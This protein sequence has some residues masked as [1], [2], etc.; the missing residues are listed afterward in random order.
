MTKKL[1]RLAAVQAVLAWVV[2]GYI[3]F[4]HRTI[5]WEH[6][7]QEHLAAVRGR[8]LPVLAAFWHGRFMMIRFL[9][10][11]DRRFSILISTHRDG[12]LIAK[13]IER[14]D[15]ATIAGSSRRGGAAALRLIIRTL[16][17]GGGV[18]IT[19][20]GP[21]G[22]RM[23]AKGGIVAAARAAGVPILPVTFAVR[24]RIVLNSWDRF[25]LALPWTRGVYVIG[26]PVEL[27]DGD[28]E[29]LRELVEQRLN[30]IT[31][32]AD[33]RV[34]C[35]PIEPAPVGRNHARA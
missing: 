8:G 15:V 6:I 14:L 3:R 35:A 32:L 27:A 9:W 20:D 16:G 18:G 26:Q 11:E 25:V 4:V 29:V 1:L 30:E 34:G 2:A 5:R 22:P 23:R 10:T 7:G 13:S 17:E 33:H 24:R 19:P 12:R 28:D 21:K 31:E